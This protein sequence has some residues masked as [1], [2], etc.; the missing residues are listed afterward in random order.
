MQPIGVM[1]PRFDVPLPPLY[2]GSRPLQPYPA[3]LVPVPS[4]LRP[5]VLARQR[6]RLWRPPTSQLPPV[7]SGSDDLLSPADVR[8]IE[9]VLSFAWAASTSE[10]YGTGLLIFHVVCDRKQ[11]SEAERAPAHPAVVLAFLAT[12]SG[13]YSGG[14]IRNYYYGLRAWHI[15]H[16]CP[17]LLPHDVADSM[18]SAADRLSPP[19]SRLGKRPPYTVDILLA[20][21]GQLSLLQPLDAAVWACLTSA[22]YAVARVG[23][24]TV[25]TLDGFDPTRHVKRSDVRTERDRNHLEETVLFIPSTKAA[26]VAGEDIFW[27]VQLGPTD[28]SA[29]LASHLLI[30]DLPLDAPLFAFRHAKGVR[31]LTRRAFIARLTS[32]A[33][34]VGIDPIQGHGIRVGGTLEYLLRGVPF[35]VV[36]SKGRWAG[37]SFSIYLRKHAQVMAPYMQAVPDLRDGLVRY[38]MPPVR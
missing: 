18:L 14:T 6:L 1:H 22:F 13:A 26:P 7:A 24:L 27:A 37:D 10:T 23:E 38:S 11:I 28:P 16:G 36:K 35:D 4:P 30:N 21:R 2:S 8:R 31:P 34:A 15:L 29:A 9:D 3:D 32:A 12:V 17:W 5:H 20:L 19:A 25:R 33:R